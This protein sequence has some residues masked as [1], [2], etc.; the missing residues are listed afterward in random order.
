[1]G[2]YRCAVLSEEKEILSEEGSIQLEGEFIV[3]SIIS[4][5]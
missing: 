2:S 4:T 1:M 3:N 5:K